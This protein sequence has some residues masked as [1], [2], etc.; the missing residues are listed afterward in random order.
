MSQEIIDASWF[1]TLPE[2]G[3]KAVLSNGLGNS[4]LHEGL[5]YAVPIWWVA[6]DGEWNL[7]LRN[8]SACLLDCG[9][10]AFAVTAAHVFEEYR[11]AKSSASN[12]VCQI[13]NALL[14]PEAQLID[15]D[16]VA[17]IA[18]FRIGASDVASRGFRRNHEACRRVGIS[19]PRCLIE[20]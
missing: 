16:P 15:C 3:K 7:E 5:N 14:D 1:N 10:G 4:L 12:I 9:R 11:V 13:G 8:G 6:V 17:D 2:E 20:R 19:S 18:T